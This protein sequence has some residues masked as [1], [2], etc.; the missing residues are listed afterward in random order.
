MARYYKYNEKVMSSTYEEL[1]K[2]DGPVFMYS[3]F[4]MPHTPFLKDKEGGVRKFSDAFKEKKSDADKNYIQYLQYANSELIK[5]VDLIQQKQKNAIIIIASDHGNRMVQVRDRQKDYDN[6]LAIYT[7]DKNYNGL[8][9]STCTVNLF[10]ILLNRYFNQSLPLL[11]CK[12]FD[13]AKGHI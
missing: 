5:M 8:T 10:R 3:H 6:I 4:I 9:N 2:T 1:H 13:V 11:E 7:S 12:K